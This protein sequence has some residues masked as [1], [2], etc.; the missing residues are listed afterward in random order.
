[1]VYDRA[2]MAARYAALGRLVDGA[3]SASP[4]RCSPPSAL[5]IVPA[6]LGLLHDAA[7]AFLDAHLPEAVAP[8]LVAVPLFWLAEAPGSTRPILDLGDLAGIDWPVVVL[9]AG[10][11]CLGSLMMQTGVAIA[12]GELLAQ[13]RAERQQPGAVRHLLRCWRSR[14]RR[15]PRTPPAPT[16]WCRW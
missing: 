15:R 7:G 10:G 6:L 14:C 8:L 12:L 4:W 16:W 11:M 5:W 13:L 1:M 3:R 2:Q 9:F